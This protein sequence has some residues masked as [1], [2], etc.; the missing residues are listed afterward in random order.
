MEK[1]SDEKRLE[2][3]PVVREFPEVFLE[4]LPSL[5][6]ELSNQLSRVSYRGFILTNTSL[7][8]APVLFVRKKD[9]SFRMRI[10]YWEL[11]KLTSMDFMLTP[12][13]VIEALRIVHLLHTPQK[14]VI[15]RT[16]QA[17]IE[18]LSKIHRRLP[19]YLTELTQKNISNIWGETNCDASHQG[20]GALLMQREKVILQMA[21]RQLNLIEGE[22]IRYSHDPN[23][24]T[25]P[26]L[27]QHHWEKSPV[28]MQ[29][30]FLLGQVGDVQLTGPEKIHETTEKIVQIRQR[31]QAARDQQRSYANLRLDDR[32]QLCGQKPVEIMDQEVQATK[33][34]VVMSIIKISTCLGIMG[35]LLIGI[36]VI[37]VPGWPTLRTK[38]HGVAVL[39]G[40]L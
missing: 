15:H 34:I 5:P 18:D 38:E 36:P 28:R 2:D 31:L 40:L 27:R 30:P 14:Y 26:V 29:S 24:I 23:D 7:W 10:D 20:L 37:S 17:I 19:K 3:I 35:S 25:M 22:T 33:S 1:K 6:L 21:S 39:A 12:S 8:G 13:H 16:C 11:N 4:D 9:G 32:T